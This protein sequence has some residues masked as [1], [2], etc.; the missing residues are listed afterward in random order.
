[1]TTRTQD[2][3]KILQAVS[4]LNAHNIYPTKA[5]VVRRAFSGKLKQDQRR[6]VYDLIE[7]MVC[8]TWD[9]AAHGPHNYRITSQGKELINRETMTV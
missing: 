3:I 7:Y 9:L 8:A 6:S 1:M 2:T 5:E 4:D